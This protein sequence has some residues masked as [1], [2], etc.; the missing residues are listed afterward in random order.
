MCYINHHLYSSIIQTLLNTLE[1]IIV[2]FD[3]T[4]PTITITQNYGILDSVNLQDYRTAVESLDMDAPPRYSQIGVLTPRYR[5]SVRFAS[6]SPEVHVI[7]SGMETWQNGEEALEVSENDRANAET[8]WR[9]SYALASAWEVQDAAD[10]FSA[11]PERVS[12]KQTARPATPGPQSLRRELVESMSQA[13][14]QPIPSRAYTM[15]AQTE[16]RLQSRP[17]AGTSGQPRFERALTDHQFADFLGTEKLA[18]TDK[19]M[20][21]R[22]ASLHPLEHIATVAFRKVR[23]S[24]TKA[25]ALVEQKMR[26]K[27]T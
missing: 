6:E 18:N 8:L 21:D 15:P 2:H 10:Y 13:R 17:I 22:R 24:S 1:A 23:K 26:V 12:R 14:Q 3:I 16:S 27:R 11:V 4:I 9:D 20:R 7:P 25:V 19:D 5:K